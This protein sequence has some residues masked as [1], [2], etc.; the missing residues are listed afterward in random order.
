MH[1]LLSLYNP[2][3]DLEYEFMPKLDQVSL[4]LWHGAGDGL[5]RIYHTSL[6]EW[7][8]SEANKGKFYYIKKQNGHNRLAKY[9]LKKAVK[10]NSPLK[11]DEAFHLASQIVEGGLGEFMVQQF[12]SLP[13]SHINTTD[14]V[15]RTTALHH[16]SSCLNADVTKL[17]VHHFCNVDCLDNSQRTPSLIAATLG[18]LNNLKILF[19]RGANLSHTAKHL[20]DEIASNSEDPVNECQKKLCGYSLLHTAAQEGNIDVVNFLLQHEVNIMRTTE[21]NNTPVQLAAANGHLQI[22]QTLKKAGGVL[23]GISLH[24]ASTRGHNRVVQYLLGEGI[25]DTCVHDIPSFIFSDQNDDESK[26]SKIR[27]YDNRHFYLRE[28][29]LHAAVKGGHLSVIKSLLSENQSAIN[30]ANSAGR[31]PLHEAVHTNNYNILE[32]LLTTG[33]N[34]SVSCDNAIKSTQFEPPLLDSLAQ[35]HC[36]CGFS[37]LHIAAMYGYHSAAEL[38]IKYGAN[39]SAGDCTGS[40]PLHIASCHAMLSLVTLL[41]KSGANINAA[42]LNGSTPLHSAAACFAKTVLRPLF[43]LGCDHYTTDDEGMTALHYVVKDIDVVSSEYLVDLYARQPKDWI[44][45]EKG[46]Y[47]QETVSKTNEEY[48]WLDALIELVICSAT[49]KTTRTTKDTQ[50]V[51]M[52]DKA[53]RTVWDKIQ[54]KTI[55]SY[56]LLGSDDFGGGVFVLLLTPLGFSYDFTFNEVIKSVIRQKK[57]LNMLPRSILRFIVRTYQTMFPES[58]NCSTLLHLVTYNHVLATNYLLQLGFDVNCRDVSG[59]SPLLVYLRTGGRH[60]SK[61]LVKHN[62]E[63][64]ITCGDPFENSVFHLASYHKLHYLH[65]LYEFLL[66]SDKWQ[67]YL[68]TENAMFDYFVDRYEEEETKG[69]VE[70][71]KTGDGPLTLAVLSHPKGTH[72]IDECFDAEGY[73][74]LHRAAQGGNLIAIQKYLSLGANPF[75][76]TLDG[77]SPLWLSVRYAIKYRPFLG[78]ERPSVLTALEVEVASLSA[79]ALLSH[80]LQYTT[81]NIGC[82]RRRSD[83]T[84]YHIAASRGMWKF[85]KQLLSSSRII[86]IDINCPNKDGITPMYLAKFFGG[87]SCELDSP[88]CKVVDVIKSFGGNLQHPTLESEYILIDTF[89][90]RFATT[91]DVDP[92]EQKMAL[93]Q[94]NG[95]HNCQNYT[96]VTAFHVLGAYGDFERICSDYQTKREICVTFKEECPTENLRLPHLD[97]VLRLL[98]SQRE[99]ISSF[100]SI[101]NCFTH[102]LDN[103]IKQVKELLSYAFASHSEVSTEHFQ[104]NW[105]RQLSRLQL[106]VRDDPQFY[107]I[108]SCP[109]GKRAMGLYT[110]YHIYKRLLDSVLENLDQVKSVISRTLPRFLAKMDSALRNFEKALNCDWEAVSVKHVQLEFYLRT[111]QRIW[112]Y[113]RT[114][115]QL[116]TSDFLS[117]RIKN[118][119]LQPSNELIKLLLRLASKQSSDSFTYIENLTFKIPPLWRNKDKKFFE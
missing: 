40:T 119:L 100:F 42:S 58:M 80:V 3:L 44:E 77:F 21:A 73:N 15:T 41:I 106:R 92:S 68:Q 47:Q 93:W 39:V 103:E 88:W 33:T 6:S 109:F 99:I 50:F 12:L 57:T 87:D 16:S 30:C 82:D 60:M 51:S 76:K 97:Y 10:N 24:H 27:L 1:S 34:A 65:Y 81:V 31:L 22:V 63:V 91:L 117:R 36:P 107:G 32:A 45:K 54:R 98:D 116:V 46:V 29:A 13:S 55:V 25:K 4:F 5:I 78:L 72:V 74:A 26:A 59:L 61:V 113:H 43:D 115:L 102:S 66:G 23:D 67:K 118:V 94:H 75:V 53:N 7:L 18:H 17:L 71:I 62:V 35:N 28:T 48:R 49:T 38:L 2:T 104:N 52:V 90:Q 8:T 79:S 112:T 9:Y 105:E 111:L 114:S 96:T 110:W 20:D 89:S 84:L 108:I 83:L 19:E 64:E 14:P 56:V 70:T 11:P 85:I 37:P 69:N 86:G 101:Q 95:R